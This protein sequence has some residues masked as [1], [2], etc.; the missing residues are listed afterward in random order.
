MKRI[1]ELGAG[2]NYYKGNNDEEVIHIDFLML[3]HIEVIHDLDSYPY[4]FKDNEFDEVRASH[5]IE[6]LKDL[7]NNQGKL[8]GIN[9]IGYRPSDPREIPLLD[10]SLAGL[11]WG[12]GAL[13]GEKLDIYETIRRLDRNGIEIRVNSAA[14]DELKLLTALDGP[15]GIRNYSFSANL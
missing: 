3:P 12:Y 1:L 5:I 10:E 9:A 4:P 2:K 14:P 13:T 15:L 6:H 7:I 8:S 11:I